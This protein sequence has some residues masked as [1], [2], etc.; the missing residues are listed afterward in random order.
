MFAITTVA[1]CRWVGDE[2]GLSARRGGGLAIELVGSTHGGIPSC[3]SLERQWAGRDAVVGWGGDGISQSVCSS[4]GL[5]VDRVSKN[6]CSYKYRATARSSR[7]PAV[8][9]RP[10]KEALRRE[11][12]R[13]ECNQASRSVDTE[14][15]VDYRE[16][17]WKNTH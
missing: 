12:K 13:L 14:R 10:A 1:A 9:R 17:E 4:L 3:S 11:R 8:G 2:R 5:D 7:G 6:D 15:K 16:L